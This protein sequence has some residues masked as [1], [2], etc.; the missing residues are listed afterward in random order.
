MAKIYQFN[1]IDGRNQ[2]YVD[3]LQRISDATTNIMGSLPWTKPVAIANA[4]LGES[5]LEITP[6]TFVVI[7]GVVFGCDTTATVSVSQYLYAI[8]EYD[9]TQPRN[10]ADGGNYQQAVV[11]YLKVSDSRL[12]DTDYNNVKTFPGIG[13]Y[14]IASIGKEGDPDNEIHFRGDGTTIPFDLSLVVPSGGITSDLI[15]PGA[16]G[17]E[18]IAY[19]AVTSTK[20]GTGAVS[21]NKI[22]GG[23]VTTQKIA[24]H[25]VTRQEL[26]NDLDLQTKFS[27]GVVRDS[28]SLT[29]PMVAMFA[30]LSQS[31]Y[32]LYVADTHLMDDYLLPITLLVWNSELSSKTL[33]I[34]RNNSGGSTIM[35][36]VLKQSSRYRIDIW[37]AKNHV[38][39]C[40][41]KVEANSYN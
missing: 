24:A 4:K 6:D 15:G 40:F 38:A 32:E 12:S 33:L 1:H 31:S 30:T 26:D 25:A 16:V 22:A 41:S 8:C 5:G 13:E 21:T 18:D 34:K 10:K 35:Q 36:V 29:A 39:T 3:D 7:N 14:I 27:G 28:M 23:A 19:A 9:T 37:V 2:I 17:T 20:I 11:R